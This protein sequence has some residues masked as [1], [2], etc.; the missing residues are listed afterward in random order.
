MESTE[1]LTK[2]NNA[3]SALISKAA[4]KQPH[5]QE[6]KQVLIDLQDVIV[7]GEFKNLNS[8]NIWKCLT[9]KEEKDLTDAMNIFYLDYVIGQMM[10]HGSYDQHL[11]QTLLRLFPIGYFDLQYNVEG[12]KDTQRAFKEVHQDFP[13]FQQSANLKEY[14]PPI[15]INTDVDLFNIQKDPFVTTKLNKLF[16]ENKYYLAI[17]IFMRAAKCC[18]ILNALNSKAGCKDGYDRIMGKVAEQ[19]S[20]LEKYKNMRD[21]QI[22]RTLMHAIDANQT[23]KLMISD[24]LR[25]M[26]VFNDVDELNNA[27]MALNKTFKVTKVKNKMNEPLSQVSVNFLI[28]I[29]FIY[30]D[31]HTRIK[32]GTVSFVAEAQLFYRHKHLT[33]K[34]LCQ[35]KLNHFL[36][37]GVRAKTPW[38]MFHLIWKIRKQ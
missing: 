29:P 14:A 23:C 38:E 15:N 4:N 17:E 30:D 21:E 31:M 19:F 28:N 33:D 12:F 24:F 20:D 34:D 13:V 36:Y 27:I 26:A 8:N 32:E 22:H 18:N 9:N 2:F 6:F 7:A 37:E 10:Q 1:A 25:C 35:M 11:F 16:E 5:D 3:V